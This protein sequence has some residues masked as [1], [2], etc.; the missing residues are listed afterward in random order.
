MQLVCRCTIG[1]FVLDSGDWARDMVKFVQG[2]IVALSEGHR[3]E[4]KRIGSASCDPRR[5]AFVLGA[6]DI[7]LAQEGQDLDEGPEETMAGLVCLDPSV[8][9]ELWWPILEPGSAKPRHWF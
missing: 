9:R 4:R 7:G 3:G 8:R 2:R 6:D 1:E 5:W